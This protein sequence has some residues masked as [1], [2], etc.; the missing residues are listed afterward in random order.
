MTYGVPSTTANATSGAEVGFDYDVLP[1]GSP[2]PSNWTAGSSAGQLVRVR[3]QGRH[4]LLSYD[5]R[6]RNTKAVSQIA[7]PGAFA[8]NV[9]ANRAGTR[10]PHT[11][12]Q[13]VRKSKPP[14]RRC[15]RSSPR[16]KSDMAAAIR[17]AYKQ[18]AGKVIQDMVGARMRAHVAEHPNSVL[19]GFRMN[20][21]KG[22]DVTLTNG[23]KHEFTTS[24]RTTLEGHLVRPSTNNGASVVESTCTSPYPANEEE[25]YNR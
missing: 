13:T 8:D 18:E 20:Y 4:S 3:D 5:T 9:L 11:T 16:G 17:D 23:I 25:A 14:A 24:N 7:K 6:A 15:R 12:P 2:A 10:R 22:P 21:G 19:A 1:P